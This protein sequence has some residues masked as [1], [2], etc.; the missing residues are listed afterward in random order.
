MKDST[1]SSEH[2]APGRKRVYSRL[3]FVTTGTS[4]DDS[5]INYFDPPVRGHESYGN[6]N[7]IGARCLIELLAF[8]TDEPSESL[9]R[10]IAEAATREIPARKGP[11]YA[12]GVGFLYGLEAFIEHALNT[13]D[14]K[15]FATDHLESYAEAARDEAAHVERTNSRFL[16]ELA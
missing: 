7:L 2:P 16:A 6:G 3:S 12:A 9:L 14:W 1:Q 4:A 13:V 11:R 15:D 5:E 8:L 10:F